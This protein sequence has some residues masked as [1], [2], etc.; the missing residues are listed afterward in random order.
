MKDYDA[1]TEELTAETEPTP[2]PTPDL[3]TVMSKLEEISA[4][5][6]RAFTV[7][8]LKNVAEEAKEAEPDPEPAP[9][10]EEEVE[11]EQTEE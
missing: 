9:E 4:Q 3:S 10:P 8:S 7:Q 1:F 5:M 11:P 2:E 6:A